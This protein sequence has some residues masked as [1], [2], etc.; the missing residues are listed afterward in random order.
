MSTTDTPNIKEALRHWGFDKNT[1]QLLCIVKGCGHRFSKNVIEEEIINHMVLKENKGRVDSSYTKE[2]IEHGLAALMVQQRNC[3]F[4]PDE[5]EATPFIHHP[6][7]HTLATHSFNKHKELPGKKHSTLEGFT[8]LIR[9]FKTAQD[10]DGLLHDEFQKRC[11]KKLAERFTCE[12]EEVDGFENA[13]GKKS[14]LSKKVEERAEMVY[15]KA[16]MG[17]TPT[18][19]GSINAWY[20]P[21]KGRTLLLNIN[22][23]SDTNAQKLRDAYD[24]Y[25]I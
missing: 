14:A 2:G 16:A 12:L 5:T 22:G 6:S 25:R 4:C 21:V 23:I 13:F 24:E 3:H 18:D 20:G 19:G 10:P 1:G 9:E 11:L 8:C 15:S 7:Y 17:G